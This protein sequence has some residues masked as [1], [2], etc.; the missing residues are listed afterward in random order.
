M[1]ERP[2]GETSGGSLTYVLQTRKPF[3]P[4]T[5]T[6]LVT[7]VIP[8]RRNTRLNSFQ[9]ALAFTQGTKTEQPGW[10]DFQLIVYDIVSISIGGWLQ[11]VI[12][13]KEILAA[14]IKLQRTDSW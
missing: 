9:A 13:A 7:I 12:H 11:V 4:L 8:S 2:G 5:I 1:G 10:N 6:T 3:M 14:S